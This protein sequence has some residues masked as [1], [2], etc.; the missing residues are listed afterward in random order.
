MLGHRTR[1]EVV[2]QQALL[3]SVTV[4]QRLAADFGLELRRERVQDQEVGVH[5]ALGAGLAAVQT[6]DRGLH[7]SVTR[8]GGAAGH[9]RRQDPLAKL[10]EHDRVRPDL[11]VVAIRLGIL[12]EHD[13]QFFGGLAS[14]ECR[15]T[16]AVELALFDHESGELGRHPIVKAHLDPFGPI[17]VEF[18][19]PQ[20]LDIVFRD[21]VSLT[22]R[23]PSR[24]RWTTSVGPAR[25]VEPLLG[26]VQ[27]EAGV[28]MARL[29]AQD[30]PALADDQIVTAF[31]PAPIGE[32]V[33]PVDVVRRES[34][35]ASVIVLLDRRGGQGVSAADTEPPSDQAWNATQNARCHRESPTGLFARFRI[36]WGVHLLF[37]GTERIA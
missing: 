24:G 29:E 14:Q 7:A 28:S 5:E 21:I 11:D 22:A 8:R 35:Q 34:G 3:G 36:E 31:G 20:P 10:G 12:L 25:A 16:A 26:D 6:E 15:T 27:K 4:D 17:R 13:E 32:R 33:V 9:D 2:E 30:G 23:A 1:Q 19:I 37:G 18:G